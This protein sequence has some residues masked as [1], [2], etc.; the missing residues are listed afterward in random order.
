MATADTSGGGGTSGGPTG[1]EHKEDLPEKPASEGT[2]VLA[3]KVSEANNSSGERT[4]VADAAEAKAKS[5]KVEPRAALPEEVDSPA[6]SAPQP[7]PTSDPTSTGSPS[8]RVTAPDANTG[9]AGGHDAL[10]LS[11][12]LPSPCPALNRNLDDFLTW[13]TLDEFGYEF[14]GVHSEH[15]VSLLVSLQGLQ[16]RLHST[17]QLLVE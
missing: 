13:R 2:N 14:K 5:S 7:P 1:Q 10:P 11:P 9:I 17:I 8:S 12:P 15:S 3:A 4:E 16:C 6:E